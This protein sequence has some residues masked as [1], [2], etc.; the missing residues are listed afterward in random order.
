[1]QTGSDEEGL[2]KWPCSWVNDCKKES[3]GQ[4]W[5]FEGKINRKLEEIL[6]EDEDGKL[7]FDTQEETIEQMNVNKDSRRVE[8]PRV[9]LLRLLSDFSGAINSGQFSLLTLF[10]VS[11]AFESVGHSI[12]V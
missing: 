1:M 8:R 10:D 3:Y 5:A 12:I 11:Y 2:K 6:W 7:N 9:F 4:K